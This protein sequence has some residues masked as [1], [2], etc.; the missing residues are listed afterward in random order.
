MQYKEATNFMSPT[1]LFSVVIFLYTRDSQQ[2]PLTAKS[3][4]MLWESLLA[5]FTGGSKK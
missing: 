3:V 2:Q 4:E 1:L 5:V